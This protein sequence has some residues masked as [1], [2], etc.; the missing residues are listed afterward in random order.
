MHAETIKEWMHKTPFV[1]FTV[2]T[3][4]GTAY[5]VD[6]PEFALLTRGGRSLHVNL[7]GGAGERVHI[8]DTALIE[9]I[10]STESP[11]TG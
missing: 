1:P 4:S 10:E 9:R 7:P 5:T 6:H 11:V 8:I 2:R 3:V